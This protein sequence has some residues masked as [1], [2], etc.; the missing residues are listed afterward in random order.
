MAN[1]SASDLAGVRIREARQR[2]GWTARELAAR[3]AKAGVPKITATVITNLE[4]RRRASRQVGLDELLALAHVLEVPPLQLMIPV[5]ADEHLEVIPGLAM[6]A[7]E[8][9]QWIGD[10][11]I[12]GRTGLIISRMPETTATLVRHSAADS[13]VSTLRL[14][15][16]ACREIASDRTP[17]DFIPLIADRIM[18]L[19]ARLESLGYDPPGLGEIGE[20]LESHDQPATL[21]QWREREATAPMEGDTD[22]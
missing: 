16:F 14:L 1:L 3:C 2:H 8:A 12:E 9:V 7:L 17:A 21:A 4:T 15:R 13:V 11:G 19:A 18:H 10:R 22:G 20:F 5:N 6:D